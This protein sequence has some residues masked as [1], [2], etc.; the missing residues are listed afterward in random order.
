MSGPIER[1]EIGPGVL[2]HVL[3]V[4][5]ILCLSFT[6]FDQIPDELAQGLMLRTLVAFGKKAAEVKLRRFAAGC[7]VRLIGYDHFAIAIPA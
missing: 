1:S 4:V 6:G 7:R 2:V 5:V 3:I